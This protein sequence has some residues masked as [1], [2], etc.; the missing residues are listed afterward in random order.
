[1]YKDLSVRKNTTYPKIR[2]LRNI[3]Q[4]VWKLDRFNINGKLNK[5]KMVY[6]KVLNDLRNYFRQTRN[7]DSWITSSVTEQSNLEICRSRTFYSF[8]LYWSTRHSKRSGIKIYLHLR[9][10]KCLLH[11]CK[12]FHKIHILVKHTQVFTSLVRKLNEY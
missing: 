8:T 7:F 10:S 5:E 6:L 11:T 1:M 4:S 12:Q 3:L 9:L 2:H